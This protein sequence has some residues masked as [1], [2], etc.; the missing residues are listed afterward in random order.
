LKKRRARWGAPNAKLLG[1][2]FLLARGS[3]GGK[4]S[5]SGVVTEKTESRTSASNKRR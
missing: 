3:D 4:E 5:K 1:N 2:L